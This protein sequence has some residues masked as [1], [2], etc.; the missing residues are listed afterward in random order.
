LPA[1][2]SQKK[3][4]E[5]GQKKRV[6]VKKKSKKNF[7]KDKQKTDRLT[8]IVKKNQKKI[9]KGQTKNRQADVY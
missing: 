8:F 4:T 2:V 1:F 6:N 9:F 3:Q 7:L 5:G